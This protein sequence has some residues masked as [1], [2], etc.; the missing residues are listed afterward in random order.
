MSHRHSLLLALK[1]DLLVVLLLTLRDRGLLVLLVLRDQVVHV[2]LGLSEFH[3]VHTLTSVPV[4]ESLAPEHGS[5]LVTDTL[6]E[7]LDRG[8]VAD[9]GRAHLQATRRD[10][11]QS[12]LDVVRDP[13]NE[14]GGVLVLHVADLVLNLLHGDL[15]AVDGG[16]GQVTA[17][18]EVRS[19]HHVLRVEDLLSELRYRDSAE[20]VSATAGKRSETDHEE[21]QTREWHH[22]DSELTQ[23]AVELAREAQASGD[24][25]HDGG[26]EVVQV[27]VA[28]VVQLQRAHADVVEGLVVDTECLV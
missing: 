7:L 17:V 21:V 13:L 3:L 15:T 19:G 6:E 28:R 18:A 12:S 9:E 11:A 1:R 26:D 5:E 27:A 10:G 8:A 23:V 4:Q 24:A 22:V 16:A 14:V 2:A 20:A 25:G